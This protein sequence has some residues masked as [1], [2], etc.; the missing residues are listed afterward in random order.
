VQKNTYLNNKFKQTLKDKKTLVLIDGANLYYAAQTKKLRLDFTQIINFFQ[1]NTELLECIYYTAFNPEDEKQLTFIK[2]LENVGYKVVSKPLKTFKDDSKKGN[3]DVEIVV[4][5]I[6]KMQDY[7]YLVLISGDGDF[8]YLVS[9]LD[10]NGK[11]VA[12]LGVGG[13]MS[14]E[15]HQNAD[16]YF[17]LERIPSVWKHSYVKAK[18]DSEKNKSEAIE[19]N[20]N[21][22]EIPKNLPPKSEPKPKLQAQK[23]LDKLLKNEALKPVK[24]NILPI[25]NGTKQQN[26]KPNFQIQNKKNPNKQPNPNPNSARIIME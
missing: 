16:Y 12:V 20:K 23:P 18:A 24:N 1:K 4:D 8:N 10:E 6:T 15:L 3:L 7:E 14:F 11:K 25:Q 9:K 22:I 17:F 19:G 21:V 26:L 13:S 5:A 2:N